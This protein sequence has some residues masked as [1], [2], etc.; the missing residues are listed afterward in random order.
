MPL[1][2][3]FKTQL[4]F[5]TP[6]EIKMKEREEEIRRIRRKGERE[7][8]REKGKNSSHITLQLIGQLG[9]RNCEMKTLL[10]ASIGF[11]HIICLFLL[12]LKEEREDTINLKK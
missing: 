8:E 1:F 9:Q 2:I 11:C 7:R 6:K 5:S 12:N 10:K 4:S 3:Q